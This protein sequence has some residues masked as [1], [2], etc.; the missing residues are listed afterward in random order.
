MRK[1]K[2]LFDIYNPK[3]EIYDKPSMQAIYQF[4]R[5]YDYCDGHKRCILTFNHPVYFF[6]C[7]HKLKNIK[8]HVGKNKIFELDQL[9]NGIIKLTNHIKFE[10]WSNYPINFS[11]V[12][13]V[14]LEFDCDFIGDIFVGGVNCNIL[15]YQNNYYGIMFSN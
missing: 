9:D 7:H 2:I 5:Y 13:R 6:I 15:G 10:N 11:R 12:D 3:Q 4:N 8:L 1:E 14:C